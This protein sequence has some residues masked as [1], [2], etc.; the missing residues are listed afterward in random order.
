LIQDPSTGWNSPFTKPTYGTFLSAI[1][2]KYEVG[3]K[4][5]GVNFGYSGVPVISKISLEYA[6]TSYTSMQVPYGTTLV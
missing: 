4:F 1:L 6:Q 5:T 2:V 3:G